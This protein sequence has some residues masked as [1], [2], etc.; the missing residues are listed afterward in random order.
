MK[1]SGGKQKT[2]TACLRSAEGPFRP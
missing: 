2:A 1:W